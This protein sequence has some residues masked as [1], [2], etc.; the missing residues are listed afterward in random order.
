MRDDQS[1]IVP[2][3]VQRFPLYDPCVTSALDGDDSSV[4]SSG[5][6]A[7]ASTVNTIQGRK[8]A[9]NIEAAE[10]EQEDI[11]SFLARVHGKRSAALNHDV[12]SNSSGSRF[13]NEMF[14]DCQDGQA[15]VVVPPAKSAQERNTKLPRAE[16]ETR[17]K[18][19]NSAPRPSRARVRARMFTWMKVPRCKQ[20]VP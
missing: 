8:L 14:Y 7:E 13:E 5:E 16:A 4:D 20:D 9:R 6:A 17:T 10:K 11:R 3:R 15:E 1:W 12:I 19:K 18:P 2:R